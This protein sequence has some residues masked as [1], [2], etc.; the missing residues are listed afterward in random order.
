M[1]NDTIDQHVKKDGDLDIKSNAVKFGIIGGFAAIIVS[2]ILFFANLQF[3]SWSKWLQT[4]VMLAT[5]IFGIKAI[6]DANKNK[7]VPLGALFKGGMVITLIIAI[8]S[9]VYFLVYSNF[10]ETDFIDKILEVSRQQM[11]EK[12]LSEDQIERAMQMTKSFMSPAIMTVISLISS[13]IIGALTSL[14][15]AAIFKKEQ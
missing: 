14:I 1:S 10:I 12:G 15:A 13:L 3:E 6:A 7:I 2:L 11:T 4:A 5:I 9:V 8:I